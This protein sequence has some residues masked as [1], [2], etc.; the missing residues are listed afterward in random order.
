M[1]RARKFFV[2]AL[3]I[4]ATCLVPQV[5]T[6]QTFEPFTGYW[7]GTAIG[8]VSKGTQESLKCTANNSLQGVNLRIVLRCANAAGASLQIYATISQANNKLGGTWEERTYNVSGNVTGSVSTTELKAKVV[9][10]NF[11]ADV[12]VTRTDA[13]L[14][15]VVK[16]SEGTGKFE[17]AM[18]R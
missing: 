8:E 2:S 17:V 14:K 10:P 16:P 4:V 9:S 13:G 18:Q 7:R 1:N 6:A 12:T 15:V 5:A 3:L 11:K